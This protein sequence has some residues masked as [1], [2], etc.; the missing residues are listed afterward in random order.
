MYVINHQP[1]RRRRIRTAIVALAFVGLLIGGASLAPRL[2]TADTQISEPPPPKVTKVLGTQT[3]VRVFTAGPLKLDL[4]DDWEAFTP[5]DAPAGSYS[6]RNTKGNKGVRVLTAYLDNLPAD[7]AVNR[8]LAVAADGDKLTLYGSVSDNCTE[9]VAG[10]RAPVGGNGREPA[11]WSG[12]Q[13]VCDTGNYNRNLVGISSPDGQ[14]MV[15]LTGPS[16][17]HRIFLTYYDADIAP[18]FGIFTAAAESLR[19]R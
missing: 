11:R 6:W 4:P 9:F 3:K 7:M 2:L 10:G 1:Y 14:N 12:V 16:G 15:R 5:E 19:L 13:F 18:K 8:V 17:T